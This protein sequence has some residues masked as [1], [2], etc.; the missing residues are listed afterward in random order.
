MRRL[1]LPRDRKPTRR[2]TALAAVIAVV[3][4]FASMTTAG[5]AGAAVTPL[6]LATDGV[7]GIDFAGG[8]LHTVER[9]GSGDA[10]VLGRQIA[11]DGS[12]ASDRVSM[13]YAD[14]FA[15]G[16]HIK[17][18]PCDA[19]SCVPLMGAGNGDVGYVMV[20]DAGQERV[21]IH[22]SP[23][24]HHGT[25]PAVT[26]AEIVDMSGRY[27][28]YD[29]RSTGK[30][31]IDDVQPYRTT[32]VRITRPVVAASVWGTQLWTAGATAGAVT[33]TDIKTKKTVESLSTGSGCVIKELRA[34]GRWVYWNCGG[35]NGRAGVYDRTAKKS[36]AVPPGPAL[37]G[38]GYLV[39]HDR[40]A[41]KL[42]LTDFHTGT[43]AAPRPIADLPAGNTA[44]QRRL[45][46]AVDKFGGD[47]AYVGPDH[48]IHIVP[49]GVPSQPLA[50]TESDVADDYLDVK[51]N[52]WNS[53]WEFSEPV[54]WTFT[55]KD[56]GGRTVRTLTGAGT[57]EADVAWDGK[58]GA[59]VYAYNG[60]YT[61]TLTATPAEGAGTYSTGGKIGLTGGRQGHHDQGGVSHGELLTLNSQGALTLHY[62]EGKGAFDWKRS[63]SGWPA[64]SVA[65]PFGDM[66]TDRCAELLVRM[67]NGELRRY[68]GRCGE[69][70]KPT[71]SHSSLGTGWNAYNVLTAPGDLTGDGRADLVARKASTGDLYLFANDGRSKL[72]GG[73]KIGS[74]WSAY[75]HVVGAGDLNG[76]GFGDIL[77]RGKNGT[78]YRYEGTGKGTLGPRVTMSADW[79]ATYNAIVG[80]GDLTGDG[81]NDVVMRDKAGTL[82]RSNGNGKGSFGARTKI[83]TGWQGYKGL[84]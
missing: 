63:A 39:Q 59:G 35:T 71:N 40:T 14:P 53:T 11:P 82:Y 77:A 7:W 79:G 75:T 47:I 65:V 32:D 30:Q 23:N 15:D 54:A 1:T 38:D 62:T 26:G 70:Y 48:G 5:V 72:A 3:A 31:Y 74:G 6:P 84:F 21:Q 37:V 41:G 36:V 73:K 42:L 25:E 58:T 50:R 52:G 27:F 19:G 16:S 2:S 55:V 68:A 78:L 64:G 13:G 83:A 34:V 60:A 12:T 10:L 66:G 18:V 24:S 51:H 45:T 9:G 57:A 76:D 43:S 61:W 49:S 33:A 46:W 28:V 29:A 56:A 8:T 80:V 44:D 67:P 20:S 22:V 81:K 17:R 69:P 4:G